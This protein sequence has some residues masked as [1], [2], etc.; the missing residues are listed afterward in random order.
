MWRV[1]SFVVVALVSAA[2]AVVASAV[3]IIREGGKTA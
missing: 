1:V 2:V 3:W